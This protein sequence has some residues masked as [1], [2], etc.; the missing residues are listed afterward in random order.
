MADMIKSTDNFMAARM[1]PAWHGKGDVM[2]RLDY[3]YV[4]KKIGWTVEKVPMVTLLGDETTTC[5]TVRTLDNGTRV[6][7]GDKL[8]K[9]YSVIQ[10]SDMMAAV[11]PLYDSGCAIETG[12]TLDNGKRFVILLRLPGDLRAGK[13]D[14]IARYI[15][16]S[17]DHAGRESARIGFTPVRVVCANTLYMAEHGSGSQLLRLL[18]KGDATAA[19]GKAVEMIDTANGAFIAYGEF[20]DELASYNINQNDINSYVKRVFA[21]NLAEP[22]PNAKK[23]DKDKYEDQVVRLQLMQNTINELFVTEPTITDHVDTKGTAYGLYQTVNFYLNHMKKGDAEQR[24]NAMWFGRSGQE[25]RRAVAAAR[26][27]VAV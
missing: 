9:D 27:L 19:L 6:V 17:N 21:P 3:D 20:I 2:E 1:L 22:G 11:K 15:M 18:H 8:S 25:E 23:A 13:N 5:A 12:M 4:M 16:A 26:E 14:V 24:L 7:L 10:N